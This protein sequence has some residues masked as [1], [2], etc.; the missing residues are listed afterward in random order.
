MCFDDAEFSSCRLPGQNAHRPFFSPVGTAACS[1]GRQ[2]NA[3]YF[4]TIGGVFVIAERRKPPG[5][6]TVIPD[7]SRRAATK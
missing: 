7:G 3:T 4:V 6:T 1:Q 5:F 2:P